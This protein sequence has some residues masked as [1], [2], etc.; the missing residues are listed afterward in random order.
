MNRDTS[1]PPDHAGVTRDFDIF[2]RHFTPPTRTIETAQAAAEKEEA[3]D[4]ERAHGSAVSTAAS[5][6]RATR[7]YALAVLVGLPPVFVSHQFWPWPMLTMFLYALFGW[8]AAKESGAIFEFADAFYYL[9]FTLS[10]G[11]LL[12][13]TD[14]FSSAKQPVS[15]DIFHYFGLGMLTTLLGVVGRT[16]FQTFYRLPTETL[17]AVNGRVAAAAELYELRLKT[18]SE[19]VVKTAAGAAS[20]YEVVGKH[21]H[22]IDGTLKDAIARLAA[23]G[24][25]ARQLH[26]HTTAAKDA[27]DNVAKAYTASA[28]AVRSGQAHVVSATN[29]FVEGVQ[30]AAASS[31]KAGSEL[32]ALEKATAEARLAVSSFEASVSTARVDVTPLTRSITDSS[33]LIEKAGTSASHEMTNFAEA[34]GKFVSV[35][36]RVRGVASDLDTVPMRTALRQLAERVEALSGSL[37]AHNDI[38]TD[39]LTLVRTTAAGAL[40]NAQEVAAVLDEIVEVTMRKLERIGSD[41]RA[42]QH[43][44]DG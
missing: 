40:R 42:S 11:S 31:S 29:A 1:A 12:A 18:L 33:S 17:E 6:A 8:R 25:E 4:P 34:A 5:N 23:V 24:D 20:A 35:A 9:G 36:A 22:Q 14:P 13:S 2:A 28:D 32:A 43:A 39:D 7:Y 16:L 21:I 3:Q 27:V 44:R 38:V 19:S 15:E 30:S 26:E 41:P 37:K 10:V